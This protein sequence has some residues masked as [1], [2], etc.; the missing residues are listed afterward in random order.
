MAELLI[1][2]FCLTRCQSSQSYPLRTVCSEKGSCPHFRRCDTKEPE[3]RVLLGFDIGYQLVEP[4][5][6][7][8]NLRSE[9]LFTEIRSRNSPSH[10]TPSSQFP[11]G[12]KAPGALYLYLAKMSHCRVSCLAYKR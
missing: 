5:E 2:E 10:S 1:A 11:N 12:E 9:L 4:V 7:L 3:G 6:R 8:E